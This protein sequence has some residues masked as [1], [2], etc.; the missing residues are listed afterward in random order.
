MVVVP[1]VVVMVIGMVVV[2]GRVCV[3]GSGMGERGNWGRGRVEKS[4]LTLG[5]SKH[6]SSSRCGS[7][8]RR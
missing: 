7:I 1:V 4:G 8:V 5:G 2:V 3:Q 6:V